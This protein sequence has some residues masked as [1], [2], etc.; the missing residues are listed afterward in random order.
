MSSNLLNIQ[1]ISLPRASAAGVYILEFN[2]RDHL[3]V[4]LF[5][6]IYNKTSHMFCVGV[7]G[8]GESSLRTTRSQSSELR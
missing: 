8:E 1:K 5:K 7:R 4:M 2:S 3:S 6:D